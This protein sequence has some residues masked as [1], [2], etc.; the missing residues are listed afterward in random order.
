[1]DTSNINKILLK[2]FN[3]SQKLGEKSM[4]STVKYDDFMNGIVERIKAYDTDTLTS[5]LMTMI[6]LG[7]LEQ[8]SGNFYKYKDF[9]ILELLKRDGADYSDKLKTI[10]KL[11]LD[12]AQKH[13]ET[14]DKENRIFIITQIPGTE[15]GNLTPLWKFGR[16]NVSKENKLAAFKDLQ[17]LT[18]AGLTDD[19][20]SRSNELW[21]VNND[22]KIIIPTFA[23]LRPIDKTENSKEIIE[24]YY[25]ILFK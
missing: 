4:S 18:S 9:H 22:N 1:M 14:I 16:D 24:K 19:S 21:F 17:K 20:I 2:Q 12:I 11:N 15:K 6:K 23:R 25:N 7:K 13:I 10:N 3:N 5:S 8:V